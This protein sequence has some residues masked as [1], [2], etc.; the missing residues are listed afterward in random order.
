MKLDMDNI[1]NI[2]LDLEENLDYGKEFTQINMKTRADFL[3]I[4]LNDYL[5]T[6]DRLLEANFLNGKANNTKDPKT[7]YISSISYVGHQFIADISDDK[8]WKD[9]RRIAI[10]SGSTSIVFVSEIAKK[11]VKEVMNDNFYEE[12]YDPDKTNLNNLTFGSFR[13]DEDPR[14]IWSDYLEDLDPTDIPE[15]RFTDKYDTGTDYTLRE[16]LVLIWWLKPARSRELDAR[17][18]DYFIND[19]VESVSKVTQ[20]FIDDNVIYINDD[21]LIK[22]T[23]IGQMIFNR[24]EDDLWEIHSKTKAILDNVFDNWNFIA[25][26]I[27]V[28]NTEIDRYYRNINY[29]EDLISWEK[30]NDSYTFADSLSRSILARDNC[31]KKIENLKVK[32]KA[33]EYELHNEIEK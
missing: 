28:N 32:N 19:Y 23:V 29:Y 24:F 4:N 20:K 2:L 25:Y 6:I 1:R 5:Y 27:Q 26:K 30:R 18:P 12:F 31:Q 33:L 9:A 10:K 15:G 14:P 16:I 8:N 3:K 7:P 22:P 11:I 21:N 17:T 13:K